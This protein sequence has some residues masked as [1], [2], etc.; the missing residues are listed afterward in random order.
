MSRA[1]QSSKLKR[2]KVLKLA[3]GYRGRANNCPSIAVEKLEKAL[4]YAY[5]DRR[6]KKRDFRSLWIQRINASVRPHGLN[7]STFMNYANK[8]GLELNRKMISE[9]AIADPKA[10]EDLVNQVIKLQQ[11]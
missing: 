2:K 4:R 3:K 7:Y 10:F 9:L 6:R 11:A 5:R 8:A 1:G